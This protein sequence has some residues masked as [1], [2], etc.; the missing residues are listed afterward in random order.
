MSPDDIA[1]AVRAIHGAYVH[2]E[3][4]QSLAADYEL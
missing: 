3:R 1:K 4:R 2:A